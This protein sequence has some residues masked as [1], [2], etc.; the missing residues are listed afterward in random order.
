MS[1]PTRA[2]LSVKALSNLNLSKAPSRKKSPA[3]QA[4]VRSALSTLQPHR[5]VRLGTGEAHYE[6]GRMTYLDD[7]NG[8]TWDEQ[9]DYNDDDIPF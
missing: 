5:T 3:R 2:K 9:D 6:Y 1:K 8:N 7:G 4:R